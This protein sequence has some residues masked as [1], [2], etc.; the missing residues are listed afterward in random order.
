MLSLL[1]RK[2]QVLESRL[3]TKIKQW[4]AENRQFDNTLDASQKII[5]QDKIDALWTEI[6]QL[7]EQLSELELKQEQ[8]DDSDVSSST[9]GQVNGQEQHSSYRGRNLDFDRKFPKIDFEEPA[10]ILREV[11]E[12]F[13][14]K[15]GDALFL[16]Q[17]SRTRG[18][19]W[20]LARIREILKDDA[21]EIE[22]VFLHH[23]VDFSACQ[24][25]LD[26]V[27]VLEEL[28]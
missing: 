26:E 27:G 19:K 6:E 23:P 22:N 7:E 20:C 25:R 5:M 17:N 24:S 15:G 12:G 4:E 16:L 18:G 28:G 8:D 1:E 14:W 10:S 9:S 2:K 21:D 13:D 11:L 3:A